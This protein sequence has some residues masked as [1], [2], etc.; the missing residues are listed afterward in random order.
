MKAGFYLLLSIIFL[1]NGCLMDADEKEIAE[2]LKVFVVSMENRDEGLARAC[3]MDVNG[4][5]VLNPD[6][7]ARVDADSFT[8]S[9]M[10]ELIHNYRA[11]SVYFENRVLKFKSIQIGDQWYQYRGRQAFKDNI[12]TIKAD[13]N[14]I[15]IKIRGI[16]KIE[17]KW[18][19][20]D[21][22]G[23]DFIE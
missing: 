12:M 18:R 5:M 11:L 8:E 10:A 6:V 20:V 9:V 7:S 3:L 19:I 15:E 21:L 14:Q 1:F 16:V 2:M 17:D 22:S 13:D 23:I 4:F